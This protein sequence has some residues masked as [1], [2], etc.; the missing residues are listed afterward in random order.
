MVT[1]TD[2]R[3]L[4]VDAERAA[5]ELEALAPYSPAG[6]RTLRVVVDETPFGLGYYPRA[7]LEVTC[8]YAP[9]T[10]ARCLYGRVRRLVERAG[11]RRKTVMRYAAL[12][13]GYSYVLTREQALEYLE[14][15]VLPVPAYTP[16]AD[17]GSDPFRGLS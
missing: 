1:R 13:E 16:P 12:H 4:L 6:D 3:T 17:D 7:A 5:R 11:E 15:G 9:S 14:T 10:E 8:G 2:A